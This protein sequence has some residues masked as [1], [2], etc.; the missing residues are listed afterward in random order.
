MLTSML[1]QLTCQELWYFPS[2]SQGSIVLD[3]SSVEITMF[4]ADDNDTL[5]LARQDLN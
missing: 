5:A 4:I 2:P 1:D 3:K